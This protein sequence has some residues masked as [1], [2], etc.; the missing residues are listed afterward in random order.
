[1]C[2]TS[3]GSRASIVG[4]HQRPALYG[5]N[6]TVLV[7]LFVLMEVQSSPARRSVAD[8]RAKADEYRR[9]AKCARTMTT[10]SALFKLADRYDGV[11]DARELQ[12][13]QQYGDR[14]RV[15]EL[16]A[17][18]RSVQLPFNADHLKSS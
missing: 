3:G 11:A 4:Y 16:G 10:V 8:L 7:L 14:E 6:L 5:C 1:M 2:A 12:P 15:P 17:R 9:M 13:G 18:D